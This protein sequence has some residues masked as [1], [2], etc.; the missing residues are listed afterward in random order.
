MGTKSNPAANDC[1]AKAE[2]NEPLFTL[3]AR[4][5]HAPT[6]VW[7][8]AVLR[9]LDGEAPDTLH[10]A[11]QLVVDMIDWQLALGKKPVGIAASVLAGVCEMIRAVNHSVKGAKNEP[12]TVA[13]FRQF[14]CA[15]EFERPA[16]GEEKIGRAPDPAPGA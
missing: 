13:D 10:E 12:L 9:E 11:R 6:L 16:D 2:P 4:D 3:L 8:W 1:Y 14:L 15:A 5:K 7:L